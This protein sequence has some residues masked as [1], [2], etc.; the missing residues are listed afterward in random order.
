MGETRLD[1][2]VG[3]LQHLFQSSTDMCQVTTK[4]SSF[5]LAKEN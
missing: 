5:L 1:A 3:V 4:P 2:T